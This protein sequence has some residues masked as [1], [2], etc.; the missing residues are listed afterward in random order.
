MGRDR[1]SKA[2]IVEMTKNLVIERDR[3]RLVVDIG[4]PVDDQ[5][6]MTEA[7]EQAR[8]NGTGRPEADDEHVIV[9][10]AGRI[11]HVPAVVK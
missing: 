5:C 3:T 4:E 7:A 1:V 2:H 8:G 6:A 9:G 10:G 11:R